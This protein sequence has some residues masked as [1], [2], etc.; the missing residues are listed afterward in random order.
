[1]PLA[2]GNWTKAKVGIICIDEKNWLLETLRER[3]FEDAPRKSLALRIV[4]ASVWMLKL[5]LGIAFYIVWTEKR[6]NLV[7]L[8]EKCFS[9]T[10]SY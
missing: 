1:L 3:A 2:W 8:P 9:E 4:A 10:H 5:R 6:R 7:C